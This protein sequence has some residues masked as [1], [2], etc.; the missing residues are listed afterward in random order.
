MSVFFKLLFFQN[1]NFDEI[2][3]SACSLSSF[4]I[5]FYVFKR[6]NILQK[7]HL[8]VSLIYSHE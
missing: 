7:L 3:Q 6:S 1:L 5:T 4:L 8:I 2:I